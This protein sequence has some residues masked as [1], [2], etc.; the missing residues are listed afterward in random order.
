MP[1]FWRAP[2]QI[3]TIKK[4]I[5]LIPND[6]AVVTQDL[7]VCHLSQR[8]E[9]YLY[10]DNLFAGEFILL[11]VQSSTYPV[12]NSKILASDLQ[13]LL[14]NN[15]FG[16]I[17]SEGS[18]ILFQKGVEDKIQPSAEILNFLDKNK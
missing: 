8:K 7:I 4:A 13:K 9:I 11:N 6:A 17:M 1:S 10:P 18:T 15:N 16:I 3:E 5:R 14:A 2:A 12:M